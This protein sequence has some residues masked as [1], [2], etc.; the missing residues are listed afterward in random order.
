MIVDFVQFVSHYFYALCGCKYI[1]V[2][3]T[4]H[5]CVLT[6][7]HHW[8]YSTIISLFPDSNFLECRDKTI[9]VY[10]SPLDKIITDGDRIMYVSLFFIVKYRK[11]T[12]YIPD[13]I[14]NFI[15]RYPTNFL[16]CVFIVN[17]SWSKYY[18][19]DRKEISTESPPYLFVVYIL[20]WHQAFME[21]LST[22]WYLRE[23][24]SCSF[25][26]WVFS[27][28]LLSLVVAIL[29]YWD[30]E[31]RGVEEGGRGLLLCC[32]LYDWCLEVAIGTW[33]HSAFTFHWCQ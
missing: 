28:C 32:I 1:P 27:S 17:S 30:K 3:H 5:S 26:R 14:F 11:H 31:G 22:L 7:S 21:F 20:S 6:K 19:Y 4:L 29:G 8:E 23:K 18:N 10:H 15:H 24:I 25:G 13:D 2:Y 16:F 12:W 9:S 33:L